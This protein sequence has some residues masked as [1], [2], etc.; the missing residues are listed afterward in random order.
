[1][2]MGTRNVGQSL[3]DAPSPRHKPATEFRLKSQASKARATNRTTTESKVVTT[4][5]PVSPT[6]TV[7]ARAT[8]T[9]A[10]GS[11][12][13]RVPELPPDEPYHHQGGH[14]DADCNECS[15]GE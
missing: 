12:N 4:K 9:G 6:Q 11:P 5:G 8:K 14:P 7:K 1:M 13:Q 10:R 15:I 3:I 2:S